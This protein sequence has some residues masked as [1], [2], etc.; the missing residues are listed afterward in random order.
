IPNND[1]VKQS[2]YS[3]A[4]FCHPNDDTE[5]ACLDSCCRECPPLY[6]P[7]LA[8]EYLLSRLQVT[9]E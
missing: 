3:I 4:F 1:R 6:P 7:I 8:G 2:R 9:Y 5:I